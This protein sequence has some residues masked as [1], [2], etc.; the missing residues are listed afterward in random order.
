MAVKEFDT[1]INGA[2]APLTK[3]IPRR[4]FLLKLGFLLN[5]IAA[6]MVSGPLLGYLLSAFRNDGG[7]TSFIALGWL[8]SFP[9][10]QTRMAEVRNPYKLPRDGQ[11]D[12]IPFW[13]RRMEGEKIQILA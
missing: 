7:F 8:N 11:R 10:N 1:N 9:E 5:G 12:D 4:S 13:V 3:E 6:T 2:P